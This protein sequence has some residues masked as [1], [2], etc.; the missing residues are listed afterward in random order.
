VW[1]HARVLDL[2]LR[3][4]LVVDGSGAPAR[5]ADVGVRNGRIVAV[6][7]VT[8]TARAEHDVA[9]LALAPGFVDVHTH[10]DA[11]VFWDPACTPSP[12][13]GCTTVVTGNCGFS[14]APVEADDADYLM[15]MLA[16]VE[17]I[18]LA[19]LA[20]GVPWSWRTF[21]EY[22]DAVAAAAPAVN[23]GV[24]VGHSAL[25]RAVLRAG[26]DRA[27]TD[28]EIDRMRALLADALAAGGLGFSSSW[29]P[30]HVDGDGAPVP[31]RA[32][33]PDELVALAAVC[34][35]HAGTQLEFVPTTQAFEPVHSATMTA[36]ARAAARPLNWNVLIPRATGRAA[37][38][39]KL[40]VSDDAAAQGA[41]VLAL[42]YPDVIRSRA[43]FR[44]TLYDGLP[45]WAPVMTR[46][47][48]EKLAALA[49]PEVRDRLRAGAESDAAALW[50]TTVADWGGTVLAATTS[51]RFA[52][53]VGRTFA[54]IGRALGTDPFDALLDAAVADRLDTA[55]IP[56]P[57]GDDPESQAFRE[58][59]WADPRVVLGAS[60]AGAHVDMIW[61][62]DW[63]CA[64]LA[65]NRERGVLPLEAAVARISAHP[66][67]VYG[68]VDRGRIAPGCWADLVCFDP[69]TIGPG[70]PEWRDDLP[71]GAGR[72]TGA[73]TGIAAV[74]V[75]GTEIVRDGVLTGARP[76][77]VLRSGRDTATV[78][79]GRTRPGRR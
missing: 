67:A 70:L 61:T 35:D 4:A 63:A 33:T 3:G 46:P 13:F 32:A 12:Q 57:P 74:Y 1:H 34:R 23:V 65:R 47:D 56:V 73:A 55:V 42:M 66:A 59:M 16:R 31:S 22:L 62:Y 21:A 11:Q 5:V 79:P 19:T 27:A 40:A 76:G 36:M 6:G 38:E 41:E 54:D 2:C 15:R 48:A 50:R 39:A 72:L 8:E 24:M 78:T 51:P 20:A 37:T 71:G 69:D 28:A 64:F 60:D 9:G 68:L 45:G 18:P 43:T 10:Q 44:G 30:T 49:D 77:R 25:R 29:A 14:I 17:G 26:T 7:T 58:R 52:P 53:F 75:N